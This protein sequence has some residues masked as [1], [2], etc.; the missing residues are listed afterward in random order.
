M[1]EL[2]EIAIMSHS[3][4]PPPP[5]KPYFLHPFTRL[6]TYGATLENDPGS[7]PNIHRWANNHLRSNMMPF[8]DLHRH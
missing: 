8:S 7:I 1:G 4:L 6:Q 5:K 3:L 2:A